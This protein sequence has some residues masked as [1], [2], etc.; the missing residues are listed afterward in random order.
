VFG[1]PLLPRTLAAALRDVRAEKATVRVAA[2][3]ELVPHVTDARNTVVAALSDALRDLAPRVRAAAA[4]GLSDVRAHEALPALLVAIEDDDVLVRQMA[5]S[6]LGEIGDARA[7]ERLRRALQDPRPEVRFQSVIA[8]PRVTA[9]SE[10]ATLAVLAA[11]RDKDPVVCHIALRMAE[12]VAGAGTGPS[13]TAMAA[14]RERARTLLDHAA[15]EVR[16]VSAILLAE[17]R[18]P[19]ALALIV[20]VVDG[21]LRTKDRE[22]E[23]A[24]IEIAGELMLEEATR[25]LE[26]RAFGGMFGLRRDAFAFHAR[27][28]LARMGHDRAC[29]EILHE[30]SAADRDRCALAVA[31]AG[32]ARL[33]T[34]EP[35]LAAMRDGAR[36]DVRAVDEAL[37][38]LA[39]WRRV[40]SGDGSR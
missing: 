13:A 36:V 16:V 11:T 10:D 20:D 34:A 9:S 18:E 31:A 39:D 35:A 15:P 4:T 7:T 28:A 17:D 24:A 30:L 1:V 29:R 3:Q 37:Q 6:A 12:E 26:R 5:I 33:L 22:D 38:M 21:T 27:V 8:F 14:F 25:G 23:A 19:R 40:M 2:V 32:R